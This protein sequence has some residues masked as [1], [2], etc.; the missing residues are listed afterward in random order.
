MANP[1]TVTTINP[2]TFVMPSS[3]YV[4][5]AVIQYGINNTLTFETYVRPTRAISSTD[6]FTTVPAGEEYRPDLTS[7]RAYGTVDYWWL[8]LEFNGIWD[9]FDYTVGTN[10]RIP[11][12]YNL[13]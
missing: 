5:S 1:I 13:T 10:L 6:K 7:Y 12:A 2:Q 11:N 4:N 9:I 3:R 8:I